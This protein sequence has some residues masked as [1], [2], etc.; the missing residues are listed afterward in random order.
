M[1]RSFQWVVI[2]QVELE[3]PHGQIRVVETFVVIQMRPTGGL[4]A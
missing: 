4:C 2:M 3:V 1:F